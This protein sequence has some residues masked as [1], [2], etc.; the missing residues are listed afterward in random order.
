MNNKFGITKEIMLEIIHDSFKDMKFLHEWY[1]VR[2][3][4]ISNKSKSELLSKV[5]EVHASKILTKKL[6]YTVRKE[7][8]DREPDLFFEKINTP[9][10]VKV[11]STDNTWLGGEFSRRAPDY[12][13]VSW[14]GNFEEVFV[15]LTRIEKTDWPSRMEKRFYGPPF[16]AKRLFEKQDKIIFLGKLEKTNKSVKI[17][18]ERI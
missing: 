13:L 10:E 2:D 17:I 6:G 4:S 14:G 16:S 9:L 1:T 3:I 5:V 7:K 11:T 12:L 15:A 18:R 8:A